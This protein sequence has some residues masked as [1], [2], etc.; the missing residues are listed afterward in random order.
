MNEFT[1]EYFEEL[2]VE[3]TKRYWDLKYSEP[4]LTKPLLLPWQQ[5]Q[6][7]HDHIFKEKL[8]NMNENEIAEWNAKQIKEWPEMI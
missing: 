2:R 6:C 4:D 5:E 7:A 3:A 8:A 1:K